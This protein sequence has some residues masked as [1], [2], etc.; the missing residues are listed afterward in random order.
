MGSLGGLGKEASYPR[1][2]RNQRGI[3]YPCLHSRNYYLLRASALGTHRS[4][5]GGYHF[6]PFDFE[7]GSFL[8]RGGRLNM[9]D[10]F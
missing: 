7:W 10:T 3:G 9:E 6:G 8:D 5:N 2:P 1:Y 4:D